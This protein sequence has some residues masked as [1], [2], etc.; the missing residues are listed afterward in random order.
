MFATK[1]DQRRFQELE[2]SYDPMTQCAL[3]PL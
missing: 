1:R 2:T 3:P